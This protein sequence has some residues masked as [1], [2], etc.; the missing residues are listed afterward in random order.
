MIAAV[1]LAIL[2]RLRAAGDAG[3]LGYKLNTLETYPE[4]WDEYLAEKAP[5]APAAWAVFAGIDRGDGGA[6]RVRLPAIFGLVVMAENARA[7]EV[8]SRHGDM[9]VPGS[10][11]LV[12]DAIGLLA[13]SD[14]GLDI[15]AIEIGRVQLVR[16]PAA[17]AKRKVSMYAIELRTTL[18]VL[19]RPDALGDFET[20]HV[21]WDIPP[22]RAPVPIDAEP[23]T[24][25]IQLPDD[26]HADAVDHLT[27]ETLP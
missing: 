26:A 11:Q 17:I 8:F 23:G 4:N 10:Y 9:N 21:D 1:E 19:E 6:S 3:V 5:V 16:P 7:N 20:F 12:E 24:P 22:F 13:K 14:L 25:G 27:L 15:D 2:A 18:P